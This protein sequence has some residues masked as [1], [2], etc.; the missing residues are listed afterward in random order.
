MH[1]KNSP[2]DNDSIKY[3]DAEALSSNLCYQQT[4]IIENTATEAFRSILYELHCRG[5]F[6]ESKGNNAQTVT[7]TK[8][9]LNVSVVIQDPS[10]RQIKIDVRPWKKLNA[11]AEFAWYMT[12]NPAVECIERYLPRWTHFSDDGVNVNSQYGAIWH[13][14]IA[15]V[16][17]RLRNHECTRRAVISIYEPQYANYTGKDM[18][19]TLNLVFNVRGDKL[20]LTTYMRSNDVIWGFCNDQFAFTLLQELV[21]NELGLKLGAYVH[22]A[23]SMHIYE[24]HYAMLGYANMNLSKQTSIA[25]TTTYSNFWE[26][27]DPYVFEGLDAEHFIKFKR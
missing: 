22:N 2:Y 23:T 10:Q 19:C 13:K 14:Q 15:D 26:T 12:A 17:E 20:Y 8:E 11:A 4:T 9:L 1:T 27:L 25:K 24:R 7:R 5:E 18:P 21:A 6:V 16:I 3:N